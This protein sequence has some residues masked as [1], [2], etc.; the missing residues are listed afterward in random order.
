MDHHEESREYI[1]DLAEETLKSFEAIARVAEEKQKATASTSSDVFAYE[2]SWT[3]DSQG[4]RLDSI[5]IENMG[6]CE[7][8][9][10]EPAIA[11]VVARDDA[12]SFITY[13]I[14]RTTPVTDVPGV[15][16]LASYRA[17]VGRLA[18]LPVGS[19]FALP[20]K[21]I[22]V[23]ERAT[24]RPSRDSEGWD[25]FCREVEAKN[26]G[27]LSVDSLRAALNA[28]A[29]IPD[30]D[31]LDQLL[32]DE[33][34]AANIVDGR[35]RSV[36]VKMGLRDQPILDQYQ[37]EIFRLPLGKRLV[38]LGPPGTGKT[39]TLIRRLGQKLD[40][41]IL[42]DTEKDLIRVTE[43]SGELPHSRSWLMFTPTDLLK[44]YLKEAFA[45]ESV[46]APNHCIRTWNDYRRDLA[47]GD[48][49]ILKT[50]TGKGSLVMR[51]ELSS[52]RHSI[53]EKPIQWFS[54]FND[55][56]R[57]VYLQ[58][59]GDAAQSLA[60]SSVPEA[61]TLGRNLNA[62]LKR[63][64][65]AKI[66]STFRGLAA[67]IPR[68]LA[69]ASSAKDETDQLIK[70]SLK[71]ALRQNKNL[72]D[73][74]AVFIGGLQQ[75]Q[76]TDVDD[77]DDDEE[78]DTTLPQTTRAVA[79]NAYM[80]AVRTRARATVKGQH[81][82]K[83]SRNARILEWLGESN[84]ASLDLNDI[85]RRLLVQSSAR[86]FSNPVKG[87]LDRIPRRY[88]SFRRSCQERGVW[89]LNEGF[90][91]REVHPLE[92]DVI[93]LVI[94]R[95]ASDLLSVPEILRNVEDPNWSSLRPIQSLY[96]NQI[97]V[98]EA[99]DFSPIQLACMA[100]LAKPGIQSFFACGDFNQRLTNW[101]SRTSDDFRWISP[102]FEFREITISYR[103][104]RQL[105]ELAR[106][107][108]E[109][110]GGSGHVATLP[111]NVDNEGVSP[112]LLERADSPDEV[113]QWLAGRIR[114]VEG[115]L[116]QMPST[117]IFVK[118]EEDVAPVANALNAALADI[119]IQVKAC[120]QGQA[121][122]Q[123]NDVRVF[124]IQHIKGLE[125]EAVFFIGADDLAELHTQLFDK[126]L[127][128]GATRAATYLGITCNE[129]VPDLLEEL[130]SHFTTDWSGA[131]AGTGEGAL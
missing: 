94:L 30:E 87:Y 74:L 42:E 119:N 56:Q 36:L 46:P 122:G 23:I 129:Y 126:Y 72:L 52:F 24:L 92:L 89:Y 49:G 108:V 131:T 86:R 12:G 114:E 25:S 61:V 103:Q 65:D 29:Q 107:I 44:E 1:K 113:V 97:L 101:G 100:A 39:T 9:R 91:S 109:T 117:A 84:L 50:A 102:D 99:T 66:S 68:A 47:R 55:W 70:G 124:D 121:V 77:L 2:N 35:R 34:N 123:D 81:L 43:N 16:Y 90:E 96:R 63:A 6:S 98:D 11:R 51:D 20:K 128:V 4:R 85:G 8:L 10:I 41:E 118:S 7:R 88:R 3:S 60:E 120:H 105:N 58:E 32:S 33:Q 111:D 79:L 64:V 5:S 78:D 54:E 28:Y 18:S 80:Q 112:A 22:T 40:F 67:E 48:L 130:R 71:E 116:A 95:D 14:C 45:R 82:R 62:V 53:L 31:I 125:F 127:Y 17:P 19:T 106:A 59:L 27:P 76:G 83:S 13:Y 104:S 115:L 57:S 37:D 38:I 110:A 69:I 15:P 26:L 75:S 93:L 21:T 73:E